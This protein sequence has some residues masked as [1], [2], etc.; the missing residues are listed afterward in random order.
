MF[1]IRKEQM[2][3]FGPLGKKAFEDRTLAHIKRVFPEQSQSLGEPKVRETIQYG[4]QRAAA[5]RI[6]SER[7]VCK[8][9]DLMIL[10]GRDFDKD[11]NHSWAKSV[12]ENQNIR[13]PSSK[14][15]RLYRAAKKQETTAQPGKQT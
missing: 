14:I 4:T 13:N 5:Y 2:A 15:E 3:A 8:Y 12:L 9:I 6:V 11:L 7:D 10:Y 1:T